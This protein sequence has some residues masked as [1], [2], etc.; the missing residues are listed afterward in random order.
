MTMTSPTRTHSTPL[1][2]PL[3]REEP[4]SIMQQSQGHLEQKAIICSEIAID[5]HNHRY[6]TE[7]AAK[8][9]GFETRSDRNIE[10]ARA[11][12]MSVSAHN[13]TMLCHIYTTREGWKVDK[14]GK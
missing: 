11:P 4:H 5:K 1:T 13:N 3:S 6:R 10:T 9:A 14:R 8:S 12:R 7:R 2:P